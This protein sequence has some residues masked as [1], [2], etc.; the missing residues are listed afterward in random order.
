MGKLI[1]VLRASLLLN[2][3]WHARMMPPTHL[4]LQAIIARA[5]FK[6]A[7]YPATGSV[8]AER[9]ET[10][11]GPRWGAGLQLNHLGC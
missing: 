2:R 8:N 5:L 3:L 6:V 10:K 7:H 9:E 4:K 1:Y 11:P